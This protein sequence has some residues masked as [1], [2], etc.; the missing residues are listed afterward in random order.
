[1][2][3]A[4]DEAGVSGPYRMLGWS[5][6]GLLAWE[7]AQRMLARGDQVE[8]VAMVD[9]VMAGIHVDDADSI[10][11]KYIGL[12]RGGGISA[13]AGEGSR[14]VRERASSAFARRRYRDATESGDA[15]GVEDAERQLGPVIRRA[16]L[17]YRAEPLDAPVLYLAA[18][19]SDDEVTVDPW[20]ALQ[21]LRGFR[22]FEID[23]CHF[24]P[25]ERCIIGPNKAPELVEA[26]RAFLDG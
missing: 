9:T 12:L 5:T 15:P 16:A 20:A 10:A 6:G 13:V 18:S 24:L 25:E 8:M 7:M 1:M 11:E 26:V 23:G 17:A 19:E 14:R 22:A 2:L 21:Y 3:R 4:L